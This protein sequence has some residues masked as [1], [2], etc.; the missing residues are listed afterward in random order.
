MQVVV[1]PHPRHRA[2]RSFE[3]RTQRVGEGRLAG[4]VH[5]VHRQH[6]RGRR[7]GHA[8]GEAGQQARR[9]ARPDPARRRG[10]THP[11]HHRHPP[12]R[13][14]DDAVPHV[15]HHRTARAAAGGHRGRDRRYRNGSGGRS[16]PGR[17]APLP[18][19]AATGPC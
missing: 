3:H 10:F 8:G 19:S 7:D 13:I 4:T 9:A 15:A 11:P 5:A 2:A 12:A 17:P 16:E 14:S 6:H 1:G 18:S